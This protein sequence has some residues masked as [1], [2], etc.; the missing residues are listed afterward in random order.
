[1]GKLD[2][3]VI[4]ANILGAVRH[5]VGTVTVVLDLRTD[6]LALGV[7]QIEATYMKSLVHV[8]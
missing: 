2:S 3:D 4:A 8:S 1:M 5:G 6:K 7:L